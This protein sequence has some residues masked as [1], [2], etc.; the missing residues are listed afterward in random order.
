[1]ER[2][3]IPANLYLIIAYYNTVILGYNETFSYI[4][5]NING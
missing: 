1:M 2:A 3:D 4:H 5:L